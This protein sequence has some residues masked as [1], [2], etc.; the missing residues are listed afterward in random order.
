[1]R[2][3]TDHDIHIHSMKSYCSGNPAQNPAA[4]LAYAEKN[5]YRTLCVTD[6]MWDS[7][8]PGASDWYA[9]QSY[10]HISENLPLP[11][12]DKVKFLFGCETELK[13]DMTLGISP[14]V[15]DKLDWFIIPTTHMHIG[16][17][18]V[19]GDEGI[20]ERAELWCKRLETVLDMDLPFHKIGIAHLT[21]EHICRGHHLEVLDLIPHSEYH[22]LF[23]KAAK[24]GVGI[25]LNF[26]SLDLT[27]EALETTLLPY[28]IAKEEGCKF[29]FGSDSHHP[30]EQMHTSKENFEHIVDLLELK[31]DDKIDFLK[32]L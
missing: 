22:R 28:R 16:G 10:E 14:A 4:L 25:E 32:N 27:G 5:G 9:G 31:E 3:I 2:Y 21:C 15:M 11:Q 30:D 1:M 24:V 20:E 18:T 29:Y 19:G 13:W 23:A 17:F 26:Y 6:H 7:A 8:V 12:S